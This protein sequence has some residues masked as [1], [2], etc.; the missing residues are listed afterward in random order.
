MH[1]VEAINEEGV[2]GVHEKWSEFGVPSKGVEVG[3][4]AVEDCFLH[5]CFFRTVLPTL[6]KDFVFV[7][8]FNQLH[9]L[10]HVTFAIYDFK[11]YNRFLEDGIKFEPI[12]NQFDNDSIHLLFVHGLICRVCITHHLHDL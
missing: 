9:F 3:Q 11:I 10:D 4:R 12:E 5:D 8:V 1:G 2:D 7:G 6:Y